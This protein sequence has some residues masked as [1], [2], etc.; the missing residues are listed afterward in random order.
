MS[1]SYVE[2]KFDNGG[3]DLNNFMMSR[4]GSTCR[5]HD[6]AEGMAERR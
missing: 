3:R 4:Q 1:L 6:K 5:L 2:C